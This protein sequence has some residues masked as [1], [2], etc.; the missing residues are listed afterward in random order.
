[1]LNTPYSLD[2]AILP[3][4]L[5]LDIATSSRIDMDYIPSQLRVLNLYGCILHQ[6][7]AS[8]R[9]FPDLYELRLREISISNLMPGSITAPMLKTFYLVHK[10]RTD[11]YNV[12]PESI[13]FWLNGLPLTSPLLK[14][15]TLGRTVLALDIASQMHQFYSLQTLTFT[16]CMINKGVIAPLLTPEQTALFLPS[17]HTLKFHKSVAR[18]GWSFYELQERCK[19]ARP[20]VEV[21][22]DRYG[23]NPR[24]QDICAPDYGLFLN[25]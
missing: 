5:Y 16:S 24:L 10:A 13:T 19:V 2:G 4:L 8:P 7:S 6:P 14:H 17:L 3:A 9:H 23:W 22:V 21:I 20:S 15:L 18:G 25:P 11:D 1:M 12:T